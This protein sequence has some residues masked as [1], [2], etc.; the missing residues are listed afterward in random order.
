MTSNRKCDVRLALL[1][2]LLFTA[3]PPA[4][5]EPAAVVDPLTYASPKMGTGGFAYFH[6]S[7]FPGACVPHGLVKV[8][9]D[10]RGRYGTLPFVHYS[11]YWAGDDTVMGFSHLHLH[12]AGATDWGVLSLMP[13][14][15]GAREVLLRDEY[16]SKFSKRSELLSPGS[17]E[18]TLQKW[19]V[20]AELTASTRAAHHRYTFAEGDTPH[21]VLDLSQALSGGEVSEQVVTAVDATTLR[22][23]LLLKGGMSRGFGGNRAPVQAV[24]VRFPELDAL[25][26]Q[27]KA[28]PVRRAGHLAA[29]ELRGVVGEPL[30]ELFAAG[31]HL[32]LIR[33]PRSEL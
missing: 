14:T 27:S 4:V 11:G 9:P 7:A 12:G 19:N 33:S 17:Y 1:S 8:G 3:C 23:S 5:V 26:R 16:M 24:L 6:G 30:F 29:V 20:K 21:V 25:G 10:T 2:V 13:V 32:R 31:E 18:V 15:S 28:A 22:G